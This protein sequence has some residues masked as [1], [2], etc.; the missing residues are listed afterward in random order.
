MNNTNRRFE[1][2]CAVI[3]GGAS[4]L[5]LETAKR[6]VAEGGRVALWDI[7]PDAIDAAKKTVGADAAF[8]LDVSDHSSVAAAAAA[9]RKALGRVDILVASAG[10]TGATASVV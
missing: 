10:I 6:I 2:R 9:S 5:G 7:N 3:T 4:G 8:V 1:A